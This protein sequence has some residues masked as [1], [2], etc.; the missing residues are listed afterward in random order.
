MKFGARKPS[1]SRSI[2]AKTTGRAKRALKSSI[3]PGYGQKGTGVFKDPKKKVYN[4]VYSKT[5]FDALDPLKNSSSGKNT[6]FQSSPD[7]SGG[8]DSAAVG[9][10]IMVAML[11]AIVF[12]IFSCASCIMGG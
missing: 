5:S 7:S 11:I 6:S 2:K 3:V 4:K 12:G 8:S 1:I 10:V 9:C